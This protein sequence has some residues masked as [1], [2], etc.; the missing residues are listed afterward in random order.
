MTL[1]HLFSL[2]YLFLLLAISSNSY[3]QEQSITQGYDI[4]VAGFRIGD[5][6]AQKKVNGTQK[7]YEI[8]SLVEFWFF[9]KVHV[10]FIQ[11]ADYENGQ[12]MEAYTHSISNRGDFETFVNWETDHYEVNANTYKF[13][14]KEP[15]NQKVYSSPATLYFEEPKDGD[16]LISENFGMLTQVVEEEP[17]VYAIDVNGNTNTFYYENGVLQKV[18][19]ENS[20]KNYVIRRKDD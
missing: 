14:N 1:K 16:V 7:S 20:I 17:G 19:L 18:V 8:N 10:E 9:G 11:S 6:T 4:V 12:L 5:M 15:I 3:A 13:E 2:I